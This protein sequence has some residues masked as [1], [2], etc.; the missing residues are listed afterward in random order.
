MT[1]GWFPVDGRRGLSSARLAL[2]S[3]LR[4]CGEDLTDRRAARAVACQIDWK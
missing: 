4:V 3:A 2:V 1:N